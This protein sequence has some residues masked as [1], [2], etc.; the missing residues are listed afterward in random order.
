M[1]VKYRTQ[2]EEYYKTHH[3]KAYVITDNYGNTGQTGEWSRVG[4]TNI[5]T[6]QASSLHQFNIAICNFDKTTN[7]NIP[8]R[9]SS[10]F[11]KKLLSN[12]I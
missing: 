1:E 11:H 10:L 3:V 2:N 8:R 6:F 12:I 5:L 4:N 7:R 9:P